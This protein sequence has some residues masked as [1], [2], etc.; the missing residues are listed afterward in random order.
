MK[1][2]CNY[3]YNC[4]CYNLCFLY[5]HLH[6]WPKYCN[7]YYQIC[8]LRPEMILN[9]SWFFVSI[10]Y[11]EYWKVLKK[12]W[13]FYPNIWVGTLI[14]ITT[15]FHN[16]FRYYFYHPISSVLVSIGRSK[17][18]PTHFLLHFST[19]T[20]DIDIA[21]PSVCLSVHHVLVFCR[22]DLTYCHSYFTTW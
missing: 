1:Q 19:L 4:K 14:S 2:F 11:V 9:R 7:Y 10:P 6:F 16:C 5:A 18:T 20:R 13:F 22:N 12:S 17:N 15:N 3:T 21:I 8:C